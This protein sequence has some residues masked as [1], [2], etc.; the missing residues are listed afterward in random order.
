M[1]VKSIFAVFFFIFSTLASTLSVFYNIPIFAD[2]TYYAQITNNQTYLYSSPEQSDI[3]KIF[4][5]PQTYFVELLSIHDESYYSARYNDIYGYV[6]KS[7]IKPVKNV[8]LNPFLNNINFRIFVPS[9]ADLRSTPYNNGTINLIY[10]IPFLDN[11]IAYYGIV[12]GEELISKKGNTWYYCKYFT[13]NLSYTGYVYSPLCDC[14]TTISNNTETVEYLE[15]SELTFKNPT[16]ESS[17]EVFEGL[18]QTA[19]TII[20]IAISLPC[21]LLIYLLFK[22]SRM[23]QESSTGQETLH[24]SKSKKK[25]ITRLKHSDYFEFD[26]DF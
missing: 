14:L 24:S 11:N 25:K 3:S 17:G 18:S 2:R 20:I 8:P 15:H 23:A 21:L 13:D 26:D 19:T 4:L 1:L 6:L 10:S 5:L 16:I 22:P 7:Q 9:G 12:Q